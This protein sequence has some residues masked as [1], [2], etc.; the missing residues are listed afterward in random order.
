[1]SVQP[2]ASRE[3]TLDLLDGDGEIDVFRCHFVATEASIISVSMGPTLI[4]LLSL[5][6]C[7]VHQ[8]GCGEWA[9]DTLLRMGEDSGNQSLAMSKLFLGGRGDGDF[10]FAHGGCLLTSLNLGSCFSGL[11]LA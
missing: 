1:M 6:S 9:D 5:F 2:V 11:L 7:L 4:R 8:I 10:L 3:T